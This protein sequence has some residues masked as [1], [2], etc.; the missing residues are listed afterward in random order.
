MERFVYPPYSVYQGYSGTFTFSHSGGSAGPKQK[1]PNWKQSKGSSPFL[2]VPTTPSP[3][4]TPEPVDY[5]DSNKQVQLK[6]LLSQVSLGLTPRL[7]KVNTKE[8]GV[9]VNPWVDALVQC[10]M[11]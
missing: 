5:L 1:Q 11:G 9:Q 6:G 3:E 2:G 7:C 8:V 4:A 10:S